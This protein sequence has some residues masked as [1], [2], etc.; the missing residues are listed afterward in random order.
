MIQRV[1]TDSNFN[2][3]AYHEFDSNGIHMYSRYISYFYDHDNHCFSN[4]I[5]QITDTDGKTTTFDKQGNLQDGKIIDWYMWKE[6]VLTIGN[7][8][9]IEYANNKLMLKE[10]YHLSVNG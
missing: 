6:W 9:L 2:E 5:Y 8:H 4:R 10:T 3:I 7:E 1:V